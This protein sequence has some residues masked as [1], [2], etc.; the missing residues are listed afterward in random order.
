MA[1]FL[2]LF[3]M[4]IKKKNF[5]RH[6]I[7]NGDNFFLWETKNLI[8][9]AW[10]KYVYVTFVYKKDRFWIYMI[11]LEFCEISFKNFSN[12]GRKKSEQDIQWNNIVI[13][14]FK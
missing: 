2:R 6:L 14:K 7:H 13:L 11:L 5:F 9:K 3:H 4:K 10:E 1:P 8:S 12:Y